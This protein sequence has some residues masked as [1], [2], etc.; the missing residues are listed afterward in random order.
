MNSLE[1]AAIDAASA[2]D[3]GQIRVAN[4]D[5]YGVFT[6]AD[7]ARLFVVADGM[8]G[9]QGG[10][11]ASRVAVETIGE[12][13]RR[14]DEGPETTLLDAFRAA[15]LRIWQ[16]AQG[17]EHL[18]GMGTTGVALLLASGGPLWLAHVGDSRAYRYRNGVLERLTVDHSMVEHMR[19]HGLITA[20]EAEN[21]PDRNVILRSLGVQ[22]TVEVD[23]SA[24]PSEP[25]DRYLL[26]SD[27]L[28][29][30]VP[31]AEIAAVLEHN[32]PADAARLLVDLANQRGGPDNV[33]VQLVQIPGGETSART[34]EF[35]VASP[36]AKLPPRAPV[37]PAD[38]RI[39]I[40]AAACIGVGVILVTV[41][42][43]LVMA[44]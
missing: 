31:E 7:N 32:R 39:P 12:V 37:R 6:D 1:V 5:A 30:V 17:D 21:H 14:S 24:V 36:P 20:E 38:Q 13:F 42:L 29:G 16:M 40:V 34:Q 35:P 27:G 8:G 25:G 41:I 28:S 44:P 33:T 19:E 10:E 4:Q 3:T 9:H 43:W 22:P 11:T 23:M 26:C 2:T 18:L 15:N